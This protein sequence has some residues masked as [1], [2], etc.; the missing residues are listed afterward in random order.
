VIKKDGYSV[1]FHESKPPVVLLEGGKPTLK[2]LAEVTEEYRIQKMLV[3]C[4]PGNDDKVRGKSLEYLLRCWD[5][6]TTEQAVEVIN[7]ANRI[8]GSAGFDE[9]V[10]VRVALQLKAFTGIKDSKKEKPLSFEQ[11]MKEGGHVDLGEHLMGEPIEPEEVEPL[12]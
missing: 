6:L 5:K 9:D 7:Q 10:K 1:E 12:L 2:E 3:L 4:K 11:L 8:L